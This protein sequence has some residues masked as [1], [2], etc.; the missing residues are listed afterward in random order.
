MHVKKYSYPLF[1]VPFLKQA[2]TL[3]LF[4]CFF[5]DKAKYYFDSPKNQIKKHAMRVLQNNT[6]DNY[7]DTYINKSA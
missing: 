5:I 4:F 2:N 3:V 1:P 6:V 7:S